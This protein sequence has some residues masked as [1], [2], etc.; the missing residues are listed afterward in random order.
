MIKHENRLKLYLAPLLLLTYTVS[1]VADSTHYA[2]RT[3]Y[4]A[5]KALIPPVIDGVANEAIWQ[6]AEWADLTH[7]WLGP[8]Y[9]AED[10]QGRF[11]VVWTQ[12]RIYVRGQEV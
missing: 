12:E 6:K 4:F 11:K 9:T 1:L 7:R 3:E 8:E 5:P 10:F 2:E